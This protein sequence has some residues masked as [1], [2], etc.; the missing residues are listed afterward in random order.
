MEV[1]I[2]IECS[3]NSESTY[4]DGHN[5]LKVNVSTSRHVI[6][7]SAEFASSVQVFSLSVQGNKDSAAKSMLH[8]IN[9]NDLI[10]NASCIIV[11]LHRRLMVEHLS[12]LDSSIPSVFSQETQQAL[13]I[14][15][16]GSFVVRVYIPDMINS[17]LES[18][19]PSSDLASSI[20]D[21]LLQSG[22]AMAV[23]TGIP[24]AALEPD[25]LL[26]FHLHWM[27]R[28]NQKCT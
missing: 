9:V 15:K 24:V 28:I 3:T 6:K 20:R 17:Q 22:L 4:C 14:P 8:C 25:V 1:D 13:E 2:D 26:L 18:T 12:E 5:V 19:L 16:E 7:P 10:S 27:P 23:V 11:K 21:R